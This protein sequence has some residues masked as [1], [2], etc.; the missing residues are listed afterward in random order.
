[1]TR[2]EGKTNTTR[3][4]LPMLKMDVTGLARYEGN[5]PLPKGNIASAAIGRRS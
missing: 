4:Y 5:S 3:Y 1:M 2:R